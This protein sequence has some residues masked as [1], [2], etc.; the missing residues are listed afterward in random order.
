MRIANDKSWDMRTSAWVAK[1]EQSRRIKEEAERLGLH[2][3]ARRQFI[4]AALQTNSK[5][6]RSLK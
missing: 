6:S 3:E 4:A 1:Q 5:E 2:G